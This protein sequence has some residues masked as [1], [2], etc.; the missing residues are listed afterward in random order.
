MLLIYS[1]AG[2][3]TSSYLHPCQSYHTSQN[4]SRLPDTLYEV[5]ISFETW[6]LIKRLNHQYFSTRHKFFNRAQDQGLFKIDVHKI[7]TWSIMIFVHTLRFVFLCIHISLFPATFWNQEESSN[8]NCE[9]NRN[10]N[11]YFATM[12]NTFVFHC[13]A[14]I[15]SQFIT[16]VL[17]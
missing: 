9:P 8:N 7:T 2:Q 1:T 6:G 17:S 14:N 13:T 10:D 12:I 4:C 11:G 3:R 15:F 16:S 5:E